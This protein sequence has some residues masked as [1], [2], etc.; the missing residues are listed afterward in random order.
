MGG[1]PV[2]DEAAATSLVQQAG[3]RLIDLDELPLDARAAALDG[4]HSLLQDALAVLD[5]D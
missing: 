5:G 2:T 3:S 1:P 4:V